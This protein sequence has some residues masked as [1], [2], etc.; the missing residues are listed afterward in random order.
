[1]FEISGIAIALVIFTIAL[2]GGF[3]SKKHAGKCS[4]KSKGLFINEISSEAL[5]AEE[6]N[7]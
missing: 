1:M 6:V 7:R 3:S 4:S 2:M 5:T